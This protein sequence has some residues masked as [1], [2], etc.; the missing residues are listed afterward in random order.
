MIP[1]PFL[2]PSSTPLYLDV[3]IG[4]TTRTIL[5]LASLFLSLSLPRSLSLSSSPRLGL[6]TN[7]VA[8]RQRDHENISRAS[9]IR[10][11]RTLVRSRSLLPSPSLSSHFQI[12]EQRNLADYLTTIC[13]MCVCVYIYSRF[14]KS[15]RSLRF[16]RRAIILPLSGEERKSEYE[17]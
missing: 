15:K 12:F 6:S 14:D 8:H 5:L 4:R 17:I 10:A 2:Q 3:T 16:V 9:G 1:S 11:V 7:V 13:H